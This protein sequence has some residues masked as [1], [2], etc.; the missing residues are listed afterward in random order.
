MTE[1]MYELVG[2]TEETKYKVAVEA[3]GKNNVLSENAEITF[4]TKEHV[5]AVPIEV[6]AINIT[7]TTADI[8]W[9]R[10]EQRGIISMLATR[11]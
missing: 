10:L 1:T 4:T 5:V 2:L 11:R 8:T 3:V 7:E 6:E 9:K